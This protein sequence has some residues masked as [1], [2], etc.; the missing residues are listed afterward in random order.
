MEQ[1]QKII[2]IN[3]DIVDNL[4]ISILTIIV[5]G[6][7]RRLIVKIVIDKIEDITL[8]YRW[9]KYLTYILAIIGIIIIFPIWFGNFTSV[10]TFLGL[11]S[12]GLAIAFKDPIVNLAGWLFIMIRKPFVVGDRIQISNLKGDVIDIRIFQFTVL[13]IGNWVNA[14]QSTGRI[15]H[16]PNGKVFSEAQANYSTGFDFI[17]DEMPVLITFES[18]WKKA[19]EILGKIVT[20][21]TMHLSPGAEKQIKEAA[22][23]FLIFYKTLTPI[24]Y[25]SVKDSGVELTMRFLCDPRSRRDLEQTIWEEV[26]KEFSLC[27]DIDFAYPTQRFYNNKTEGKQS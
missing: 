27:R 2:N 19:K 17:W 24:V 8:R 10:G 7:L 21:K 16:I 6:I 5:I 15:I 20:Q 14:E 1:I 9:K 3:P 12:A 25:T 26:L 4:I 11:L 18:D 22:K 23:K 13:E